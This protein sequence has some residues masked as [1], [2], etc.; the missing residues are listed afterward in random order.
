M[1]L[2]DD[3]KKNLTDLLGRCFIMCEY[4]GNFLG[5]QVFQKELQHD[6]VHSPCVEI[7]DFDNLPRETI[8][9][10]NVQATSTVVNFVFKN[11]EKPN[12]SI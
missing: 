3:T 4:Y 7:G 6:T 1:S 8:D 11:A 5:L 9:D 2:F 10:S 12:S